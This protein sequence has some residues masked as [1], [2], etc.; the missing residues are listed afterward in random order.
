MEE[1][2]DNVVEIADH[3]EQMNKVVA[4]FIKGNNPN[5]IAKQFSLKPMQVNQMLSNW[6]ELMQGDSGIRERAKEA[7]GAADQHYSMIIQEAWKTVEQA[8]VQ[9]ALNVKA[10]SLKLIADVEQ[11]RIDMLQKAGVLEKNEMADQILETERKQE[12][13]VGILRDVTSSCPQCKQ[14]VAK[15]LSEVTKR[16]EVISVD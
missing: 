8:D 7:L 11:K 12:V 5:Q 2:M 10:Q 16:V 14:E 6:R 9:D 1:K 13:L 4:E 3:F 15:R